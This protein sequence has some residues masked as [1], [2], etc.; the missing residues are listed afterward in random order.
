MDSRSLLTLAVA[1]AC[2]AAFGVAGST[3]QSSVQ[4]TPDDA[5]DVNDNE[6]L[7]IGVDGA[8]EI[9]EAVDAGDGE[10]NDVA[11]SSGGDSGGNSDAQQDQAGPPNA[12]G[13]GDGPDQGPGPGEGSGPGPGEPSL[14]DSLLP[15]LLALLAVLVAVLVAALLYRY[16][17]RIRALFALLFGGLLGDDRTDSRSFR[18][19][20]WGAIEPT[21]PV[22][23]AWLRMV[24]QLDVD[25]PETMTAEECE[26][27]AVAAG[28]NERAV[29]SLGEAFRQARYSGR[30]VT[31]ELS[32]RARE[33]ASR[34][35]LGGGAADGTASDGYPGGTGGRGGT[36]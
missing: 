36:T 19:D 8:R 32:E 23:A 12:A 15:Y 2:I 24:H 21:N 28:M 31:D 4:T 10:E 27:A 26:R 14:L 29:G 25:R 7:P 9:R 20:S 1:V 6:W 5:I 13:G 33:S 3:L 30:P 17:E 34:L 35:G 16:R 18:V 11:G 22:Y